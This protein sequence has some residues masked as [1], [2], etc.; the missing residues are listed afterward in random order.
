MMVAATIDPDAPSRAAAEPGLH[1]AFQPIVDVIGGR[2]HA[3]EAMVGGP[4]GETGAEVSA[5]L[6]PESRGEFDRR[7]AA[8]AVHW[9]MAA[10]LGDTTARLCIP[11]HAPAAADP[12]EPMRTAILAG[13]RCGLIAQRMIFALHDYQALSGAQLADTLQL[14]RKQGC[15]TSFVGLGFGETGLG[16]CARYTPHAIMLDPDLVRGI[17]SSWSRRLVLEEL[18]PRIRKLGVRIV[19]TGVDSEP[20]FNRLRGFGIYHVRGDYIARPET[21]TLPAVALPRP[22]P[23]ETR[24]PALLHQLSSRRG[25]GSSKR[26]SGYA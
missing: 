6:A 4:R 25:A 18:A 19:A 16:T 8:A 20:V 5:G 23:V 13:K 21:G 14:H 11:V 26:S 15:Q 17:A 1:I 3:Y 22:A 12:G 10:G 7:C 9:A 2:V 24:M